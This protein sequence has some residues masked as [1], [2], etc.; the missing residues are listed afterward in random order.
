MMISVIL[1]SYNHQDF[2]KES[3]ESVLNQTYTDF[4]L[5]I[6]DDCS[7]D[8][9]WDIICKYASEYPDIITIRHD[10]NW[11]GGVVEDVVRNYAKGD[12]IAIHHSDDIWEI[13]KL[14][15]Q[16]KVLMNNPQYVA[17]FTNA[18]VIDD[19]GIIYTE[20][21]G[22]YYN[23]FECDNKNRFEWLNYFFYHGNC[24]CHPSILIRKDV[25][26]E[27]GFF[28][29]G[30]RQIPD[31]VKWIQICLKYDI[32]VLPDKLV[33]F[34]VHDAGRNTSGMRADTQVRSTIELFLML[35]E[36]EKITQREDFI[37][38]F[39]N[40][41]DFCKENA[42]ISQFALGKICTSEG[43]P[44]YT[45]LYGVKLL[46][47]V[48][49]DPVKAQII[50]DNYGYTMQEFMN[51]NGKFDIFGI[52]PRFFEQTYTVYIDNGEGY[53]ANNSYIQNYV[54]DKKEQIDCEY[55]ID[56]DITKLKGIRFDPS[57]NIMVKVRIDCVI[58]NGKQCEIFPENAYFSDE[59]YDIFINFDPI[60]NI[61]VPDLIDTKLNIKIS[62][63]IERL[64]EEDINLYTSQIFYKNRDINY[65]L[66]QK[67]NELIN[68]YNKLLND[69]KD[70][71]NIIKDLKETNDEINEKLE[72]NN[73]EL[74]SIKSLRCYKIYKKLF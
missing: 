55:V 45:R 23:L 67:N 69:Y 31:F 20:K 14:E 68:D 59:G 21:N 73:K 11:H 71:K 70:A 63:E 4:E 36:Y 18:T 56:R 1:T 16:I 28:K 24:L 13:D 9:S 72:I 65:A 39:P 37:K 27:D 44:S 6:V 41:I 74:N 46:Y 51:Q 12:Y 19:N 2:L 25:Y 22:F 54:L 30:L 47:T 42:F 29:K 3:I 5:I 15:K 48:L 8:S 53:S 38:V 32:Y 61:R 26:E 33:K 7:T 57:E 66:E 52:L 40:S 50:K 62:G 10:Y 64:S 35:S 60:Y 49:N 17:V 43:M 34:R 58:I